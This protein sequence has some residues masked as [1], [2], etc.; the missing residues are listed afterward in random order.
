M[1]S[2]S[3]LLA[4]LYCVLIAASAGM[5]TNSVWAVIGSFNVAWLITFLAAAIADAIKGRQ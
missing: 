2:F 5:L 1:N 4:L 3:T